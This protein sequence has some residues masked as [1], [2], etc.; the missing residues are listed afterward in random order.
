MISVFD[1]KEDCCG[2]TACQQ[3]CP[4]SSIEMKPDEEGFLYP[5]INQEACSDC[6]LCR[7]VCAFQNGYDTSNNFTSPYVYAVKHKKED[8]RM[9]SSSGGIFSAISDYILDNDGLVCG[10]AFDEN[11]NVVHK[12]AS[13]K[14]ER[15]EFRGS[16]YVQSN[17]NNV[18][19]EIKDLLKQN[20]VVLFTGTPC[21]NAGL[22]SYLHLANAKMGNL[23][24]CD[25]V[26]HGTP[27]PLLWMDHINFLEK[28]NNGKLIKH[29]F[30]YK[31]AG[32][33][34]YNV[35]ALF[36]NGKNK[37]NS[38]DV[39]TYAN[40]FSSD[41]ALRPS[42]YNCKYCNLF[43]TGDITIADFWGIEKS[44]PDFDDNKGISLVLI[45]TAEGQKLFENIKKNLIYKE[46]NA[47][48]C[49]Q[50]NLQYP[51]K[52]S[53]K[54]EQFWEDYRLNGYEY[55]VKKYAGY[56]YKSMLKGIIKSTLAKIG[57]L[58]FARKLVR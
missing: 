45:N 21:Q 31:K 37:L 39:K 13:T 12:I 34:G 47:K 30:R 36:D 9:A 28:K 29:S 6:G 53:E 2:C 20:K 49:L 48:D 19:S 51:S 55:I 57:L 42:C 23:V 46:N 33:R 10:V 18:Y 54:R 50:P 25:I 16:K 26:C 7:K 17:L 35:Y 44:M 40:I 5:E 11:M 15:D 27:S 32:W 8:V 58:N 38:T 41:M 1:K 24:L 3:I 52:V 43:R 56:N 22:K 4:T 14:E